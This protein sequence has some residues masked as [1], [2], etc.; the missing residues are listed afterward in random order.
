[1][2]VQLDISSVRIYIFSPSL[3][4]P[5]HPALLLSML[6]HYLSLSLSLSLSLLISPYL[7]FRFI[8]LSSSFFFSF[9]PTFIIF[10]LLNFFT[11]HVRSEH[12]LELL[13]QCHFTLMTDKKKFKKQTKMENEKYLRENKTKNISD[14]R[15]RYCAFFFINF[16]M[17]YSSFCVYAIVR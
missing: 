8:L 6:L 10:I 9:S 1:M 4:I 7:S 12:S 2:F 3:F 17:K 5:T 14:P 11:H 15:S 16:F 13:E